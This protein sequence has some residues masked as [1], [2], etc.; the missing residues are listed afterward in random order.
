MV[1]AALDEGRS[2]SLERQHAYLVLCLAVLEATAKDATH[3][4][5]WFW[6][7]LG[8]SDPDAPL[9]AH[10]APAEHHAL[11]AFH[12]EEASLATARKTL[13]AKGT[14]PGPDGSTPGSSSPRGLVRQEVL[15]AM[16]EKEKDKG[17]GKG[18]GK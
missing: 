10:L 17:A 3:D 5:A 14:T 7:L 15:K 8:T 1:A 18:D 13:G 11:A 6:P 9:K 2:Y 16:K 12:R 4:L